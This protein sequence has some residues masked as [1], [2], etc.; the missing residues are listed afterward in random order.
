MPFY[1]DKTLNRIVMQGSLTGIDSVTFAD[2]TMAVKNTELTALQNEID[3][4]LLT[5]KT[6]LDGKA[7]Q[8][9]KRNGQITTIPIN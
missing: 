4:D 9:T 8:V 1:F 7:I 2:G 6:S 3:S 5:L